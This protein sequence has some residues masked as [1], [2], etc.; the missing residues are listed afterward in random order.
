VPKNLSTN[1]AQK[2]LRNLTHYCAIFLHQKMFLLE[3][4]WNGGFL[5]LKSAKK[6]IVFLFCLFSNGPNNNELV[7]T[8]NCPFW[9][10][11]F[12]KKKL[13]KNHKNWIIYF[14]VLFFLIK[15]WKFFHNGNFWVFPIRKWVCFLDEMWCFRNGSKPDII[16]FF[17]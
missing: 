1:L 7:M 16:L 8:Q 6:K 10:Q 11:K 9:Q 15:C 4:F 5:V 12:S 14:L 3:R 13:S 2:L 17:D